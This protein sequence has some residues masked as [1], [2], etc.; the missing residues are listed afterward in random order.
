MTIPDS[1]RTIG[2][3]AF[4]NCSKLTKVWLPSTLDS[5][6]SLAFDKC[7]GIKEIYVNV[8]A[9]K[10]FEIS[11][12]VF[13]SSIWPTADVYVPEG[14]METYKKTAGW[15][16]LE[17]YSEGKREQATVGDM[18][19]EYLTVAKTATLISS[20]TEQA[21]I[22]IPEKV[23]I[24]NDSITVTSIG[25]SAFS[26]RTSV[27]RLKFSEKITSIGESAFQGCSGLKIV[28]FPSSLTSIGEK[29]FSGCN[30]ITHINSN[31]D[32][33]DAINPNVF[34]SYT[35]TLFVS[36]KD[37]YK[38]GGWEN[39][40]KVVEGCL[41]ATPTLDGFTY[42]CVQQ[43][44]SVSV[45]TLTKS[46]TTSSVVNVPSTVKAGDVTF[47]VTTI[48]ANA[49]NGNS[50]VE[51]L[52]IPGSVK[53][54]GASAFQGC[55]NLQ[56]LWLPVSLTSIGS[57]AFSGCNNL[58]R[59]CIES[60]PTIEST[61]AF[62]TYSSAKL[63]VPTG[64]LST[65]DDK[66]GW[67]DFSRRYEGYYV[68]ESPED[69][70]RAYIYMKQTEDKR[71]AI[72]YKSKITDPIKSSVTLDGNTY[73]VTIIGE[74]AF[75]GVTLDNLELPSTITEIE[76]KAF[77]NQKNLTSITLPSNLK[78]IGNDAFSGN[79]KLE[80]LI[81]SDKVEFIGD[82]AFK[83]CSSLKKLLL[84]TSLKTIGDGAFSGNSNLNDLTI[85]EGTESI[86]DNTFKDCNSLQNIVLPSTLKSIGAT[87]FDG[88]NN[89]TEV[90]SKINN[91]D[92]IESNSPS[93]PNAVLYVQEG[94]KGSYEGRWD[95]LHILEGD[96]Q[97]SDVIDGFK[98]AYS[99]VDKKALLINA[100]KT[101]DVTIPGSIKIGNI[102]YNVIAIDKAVF[103]GNTDIK[104]VVIEDH[105]K[106]IGANA[107]QGCSNLKMIELP[108]S[109][110]SIGEKAF[111][112]C[113]SLIEVVCKSDDNDFV[114]NNV[115]SLPNA[116]LYVHEGTKSWYE[117]KWSYARIY[118]GERKIDE[119]GGLLYA[120]SP[121]AD[122]AILVGIAETAEWTDGKVTIPGAISVGEPA[123]DYNVIDIADNVFKDNTAI[124]TIEI[125]ENVQSIADNAFD[126]C[127]NLNEVV[128]K[129]KNTTVISGIAF[130]LPNAILYVPDADLVEIYKSSWTFADY[131]VGNRLTTE[132]DGMSYVYA[133]G[134]KKAILVNGIA[135]KLGEEILI[136]GSIIPE[137]E[138]EEYTVIAVKENAFKGNTNIKTL[139]IEEKVKTIGANAFQGCSNLNKVWLP[140]TLESIGEKAFDGCDIDYICTSSKT[141]LVSPNINN[142]VFSKYKATLYVP[143]GTLGSYSDSDVWKTF[144]IRRV[145]T[146]KGVKIV[147]NLTYECLT[148]GEGY[149]SENVAILAKS[150]T[151]DKEVEVLSSVKL[152]GDD[153][154]Y[155]MTTISTVA[156]SGNNSRN[157]EKIIFP[158]TLR[159][160]ED[161]AFEQCTKLSVIT[162]RI[163]KEDLTEFNENVF[164]QTIYDNAT[165][166]IPNDAET[167][168]KYK[169]TDGWKYFKIWAKGEK[170]TKP[171]GSM[172]YDY[173]VGV[174]TATL[175][176]TST[177]DEVV[178]IDGNIT[179]DGVTYQVTAIGESAFN[180]NPNRGKMVKLIISENIKTIGAN[181]FQG[182]N[183]L[184][185][186]WLP[187]T[188][189]SI[190]AKAF[191]GC[192]AIT[193][194]SSKVDNPA[195][196]SENVFPTSA[197]L[198]VPKK[199]DYSSAKFSYV[200]EGELVDDLSDN[201]MTYD[202]LK[203]NKAILKKYT[204]S[205]NDVDIPSSV[206]IG[207]DSY[208]VAIIAKP[209][210]TGKTNI[211]SLVIPA[212][213]GEIDAET[214]NAC[215][216]LKW[217]E[218]KIENPISISSNVFANY[219]ATLFIPKNNVTEYE[220]KGWKFLNIYV[221]ERQETPI[222]DGCTYVYS[223][224]DKKAILIKTATN[225]KEVTVNGT[226][227]IG[228]DEYTVTAIAESV[229]KGKT[230]MESLKISE[231]IKNIGAYAFQGCTNLQKIEFPATLKKIGSNAFDGCTSLVSVTCEGKEPAEIGAGAFPSYNITVN[232]P[233]EAVDTYKG[234]TY[235][236]EFTTILGITTTVT[237]DPTGPYNITAEA[238]S[239][240]TP[241]VELWN[242]MDASG[243]YV[244]PEKVE[245]DGS[246]YMV[247]AIAAGAFE[248][249]TNLTNITIPSSVSSIGTSAFA[250]CSNLKSIT[251]KWENPLPLSVAGARGMTRSG[252]SSIFDGVNKNTCILYVPAGC[253][254]K[255]KAAAVWKEFKNI[256]EIGTTAI[257]G[258]VISEDGK[259][260]DIYNM[261]GR[262]VR[263]N[264]TSFDGLPSGVYIVNGKKVMVK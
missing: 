9:A 130:S 120:Y 139:K 149:T 35:A 162:S 76:R 30:S 247:T 153:T 85:S 142:N 195:L 202:C 260:F 196:I 44:D 185:K 60:F 26:G 261:Q 181:A 203:G 66:P 90:I 95:C 99:T 51:E 223:T 226:F 191:D 172:T 215:S 229:F 255:Y 176:G 213:V 31:I 151:T 135:E 8:P 105:I 244:I 59:V 245:I 113:N 93:M 248:D 184:K 189:T 194:V 58:T 16:R 56:K 132:I 143:N 63:F 240:A 168:A 146:F 207:N 69:V 257:N 209:A 24:G 246:D 160:I 19:Y 193:H 164:P 1:I 91:K 110:K 239:G 7:T 167:E 200:A 102:E 154:T 114:A 86:G 242:G 254:D 37:N 262:K 108:A 25:K 204:G 165:V 205:S 232:V 36:H 157:L 236:R 251:V 118:E 183:N 115:L 137:G 62:S 152:D 75:S 15:L 253:V 252:G 32:S 121:G 210:F 147:N 46:S 227:K 89:L 73:D 4:Q 34:S 111:D 94:T 54:I 243:E 104:S 263:D 80:S 187:S 231:N 131:Y 124:K 218:S 159:K 206:K 129:I 79:S 178:T 141:P 77:Q 101:G 28:E 190:G 83:G 17:K 106:T 78:I 171:V 74:S 225:D 199:S 220:N 21:D 103:K 170:K 230:K 238:G 13:A 92:A 97:I 33:P 127:T 158:E 6:G 88:C 155:K 47:K 116:T 125:G 211:E 258:V 134:D 126:G 14:A 10:L 20:T 179:I 50:S 192:N 112:G 3:G 49:F 98:Y 144:P 128:S 67:R 138:T 84:P 182:C 64:T 61:D 52:T 169:A 219:T 42:D 119:I 163:E 145:G 148:S 197:T 259:P 133:T 55:S 249:N 156:F 41:A 87:A 29:A 23:K 180:K 11:D 241:T 45:A 72:L 186:V 166:Y 53:T 122:E 221:G 38:K 57:K 123:K 65:I 150:E 96:R 136:K 22:V 214:F 100:T 70:D 68:D 48:D 175:T 18:T 12:N 177:S 208:T 235:W 216:K 117:G 224:G 228:K 161:K 2:A 43:G 71:T 174:G 5:I 198:F 264:V 40:L 109:I 233:K 234:D 201:G 82:N 81:F 107:F 188:L 237:D 217:I 222:S 27:V 173:L 212:G 250:G 140:A 39:F 256:L